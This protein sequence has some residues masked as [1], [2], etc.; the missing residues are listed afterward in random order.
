LFRT[1]SGT[2]SF[3]A[4][5]KQRQKGPQDGDHNLPILAKPVTWR[6]CAAHTIA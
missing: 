2:N 1:I 6:A 5:L 4:T 3:A